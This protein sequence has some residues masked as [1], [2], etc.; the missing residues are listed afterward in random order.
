VYPFA[1]VR[2]REEG[3]HILGDFYETD[4]SGASFAIDVGGQW[5]LLRPVREEVEDHLEFSR[6]P[7][8]WFAIRWEPPVAGCVNGLCQETHTSVDSTHVTV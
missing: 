4:P 6:A 8:N 5:A 3:G 1:S 7:E 2:L